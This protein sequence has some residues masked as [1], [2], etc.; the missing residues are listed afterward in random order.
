MARGRVFPSGDKPSVSRQREACGAGFE[1][2][3]LTRQVALA[4][5]RPGG[6]P[7]VC[8]SFMLSTMCQNTWFCHTLQSIRKWLKRNVGCAVQR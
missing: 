2:S 5:V 7:S 8:G 6:A 1:A 4:L 3:D